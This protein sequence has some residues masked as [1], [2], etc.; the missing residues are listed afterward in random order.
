M[1]ERGKTRRRMLAGG[2]EMLRERG[3]AGVTIDSILERTGTP[4]GSVYH[5]FPGGRQQII[6]ESLDLAGDAIAAILDDSVVRGPIAGLERFA[7][8]WK[9]ILRESNYNAGCPVVAV[10]VG[11]TADDRHLAPKVATIMERWRATMT[12][13]LVA[14]GVAHQRASSLGT[15]G[16]AA[17]EGAVVLCRSTRSTRPLDDV[18]GELKSLMAAAIPGE[19][20]GGLE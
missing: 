6:S 2:V 11:G 1:A 4:R 9:S 8:F 7:E 3:S 16:V 19:L 13:S 18:I 5:H 20:P 17:L 14:A 12:S 15:L 10:A